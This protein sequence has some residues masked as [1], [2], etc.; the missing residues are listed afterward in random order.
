MKEREWVFA[1][2]VAMGGS[3]CAEDI[4]RRKGRRYWGL[5][6]INYNGMGSTPPLPSKEGAGGQMVIMKSI[7]KKSGVFERYGYGDGGVWDVVEQ[8]GV[9]LNRMGIVKRSS[10]RGL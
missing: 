3:G 9:R 10:P 7:V 8:V 6:S 5:F 4:D 2:R 1:D